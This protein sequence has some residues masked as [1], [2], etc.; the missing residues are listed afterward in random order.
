M[1]HSTQGGESRF[2]TTRMQDHSANRLS[3]PKRR[4]KPVGKAPMLI[5]GDG[6]E[7]WGGIVYADSW[8]ATYWAGKDVP[9]GYYAFPASSQNFAFEPLYTDDNY[10]QPDGGAVLLGDT[11]H[12]VHDIY[13]YGT[14]YALYE[15]YDVTTWTR[16]RSEFSY[17]YGI[18]AF[19]LAYDP[20]SGKVY[21]EF[22]R[23]RQR[24][25]WLWYYRL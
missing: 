7:L 14:H 20:T 25:G 9:F 15:S 24:S 2:I 21:G 18:S 12:F 3:A 8:N 5:S 4:S 19:D 10:L 11:L 17:D 6:T 23:L 22:S 13:G 1:V 16:L